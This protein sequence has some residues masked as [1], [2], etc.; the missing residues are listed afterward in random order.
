MITVSESAARRAPRAARLGAEGRLL[1]RR[2][3]RQHDRDHGTVGIERRRHV[4]KT[5]GE[6]TRRALTIIQAAIEALGGGSR[7]SSAR[8]CSSPTSP[9]G[10]ASAPC[11]ARSSARSAR[12]RPWS[13]SRRL[14]DD[15]ALVEIEADAI[16]S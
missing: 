5:L 1:A 4:P 16:V 11:T 10:R 3:R 8:A 7:T 2:P 9:S 14:I 12:R 6:Q 15:A 13:R